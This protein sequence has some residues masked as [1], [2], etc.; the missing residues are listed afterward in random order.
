MLKTIRSFALI[1]AFILSTLFIPVTHASFPPKTDS[2]NK[3]NFSTPPGLNA[4]V[5]FWKKLY[6]EYTTRHAV[7]HDMRNLGVVDEVF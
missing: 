3:Y 1:L 6:S 7:I 5:D 4:E 2:I